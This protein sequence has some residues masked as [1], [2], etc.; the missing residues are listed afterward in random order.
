MTPLGPRPLLGHAS[1]CFTAEDAEKNEESAEMKT[2]GTYEEHRSI[3]C[4]LSVPLCALCG[5]Q[6][7]AMSGMTR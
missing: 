1:A 4:D 3:L 7:H 2:G 5:D 6:F